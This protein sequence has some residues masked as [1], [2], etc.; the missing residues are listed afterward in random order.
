MATDRTMSTT[1]NGS[2]MEGRGT[3]HEAGSGA[4]GPLEVPTYRL[5]RKVSIDQAL[6]PAPRSWSCTGAP[7]PPGMR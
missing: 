5:P 6:M 7:V 2:L 1:W 3:I 4:F